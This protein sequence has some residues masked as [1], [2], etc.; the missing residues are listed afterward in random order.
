MNVQGFLSSRPLTFKPLC[1]S[2]KIDVDSE[3]LSPE[4]RAATPTKT[5]APRPWYHSHD[6][7]EGDDYVHS[8]TTLGETGGDVEGLVVVFD[9]ASKRP[10]CSQR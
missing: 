3:P 4:L 7:S 9:A 6:M 8:G 10:F 1:S 2:S 5:A